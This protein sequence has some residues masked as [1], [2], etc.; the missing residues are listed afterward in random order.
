MENR[1]KVFGMINIL[2]GLKLGR[3]YI[4]IVNSVSFLLSSP[5]YQY[6]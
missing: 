3:I 5:E 2:L 4:N 1:Y 6:T